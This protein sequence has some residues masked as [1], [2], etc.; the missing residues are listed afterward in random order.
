MELT[1]RQIEVLQLILEG[2]CNKQ[3]AK[4]LKI[5]VAG[6]KF[7]KLKLYRKYNVNNTTTLVLKSISDNNTP[8]FV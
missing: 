1:K 2:F 8:M 3:I 7:H 5:S 6:V 4:R